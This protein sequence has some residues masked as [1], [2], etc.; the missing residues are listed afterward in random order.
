MPFWLSFFAWL[1]GAILIALP[2]F[3]YGFFS[4]NPQVKNEIM[5]IVEQVRSYQASPESN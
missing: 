2:V 4:Q 5:N 3:I 1:G